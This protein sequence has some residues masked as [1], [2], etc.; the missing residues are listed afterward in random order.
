MNQYFFK[1]TN[2][3]RNNILDQHKHVYD[4]YVTN[5]ASNNEQP[6]YVQDF[7]NDKGGVTIN[8]KGEVSTYKN[9]GINESVVESEDDESYMVSVGEQLDMIGDGDDDFEHGTFE[10]DDSDIMLISP[11]HDEYD[12]EEDDYMDYDGDDA[13]TWPGTNY[14]DDEDPEFEDMNMEDILG[15]SNEDDDDEMINSLQE[16]VNKSLDMFRRF[17]NL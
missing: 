17:K 5:Y 16:Q 13:S 1:M 12:N 15:L 9:M 4:G 8:N 7:A 6:L 3:E 14:G 2:E 10:D 11:E